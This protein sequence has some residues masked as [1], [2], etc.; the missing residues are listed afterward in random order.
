MGKRGGAQT[1]YFRGKTCYTFLMETIAAFD[2]GDKR[3]GVAFS[4]PFGQ[5]AMPSDTYFRTGRFSEDV[6]AVAQIAL[7]RG[8]SKIVCG[9]PLNA[10]GTT[11]EQTEKTRRFISALQELVGIPV[12]VEDER[13]TTLQARRDLVT[14]GVS[15]KRDK[16]K[17]SV[18]SIAAAYI[19]ESYLSKIKKGGNRMKEVRGEE[20]TGNVIELI[21]D[22][23]TTLRFELLLTFQYKNE[24]YVALTPEKTEDGQDEED[25]VE[26]AIYHIVGSE[27][28]EQL[29]PIEDDAFHDEVFAEFCAQYEDFED[30][31]EAAKLDGDG[32]DGEGDDV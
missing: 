30:A 11:S 9:L 28:D 5:Y 4:D 25:G 23:G 17:K 21:D 31:D 3:I 26:V 22:E 12:I 29:E 1:L 20:G 15:T 24:W 6:K 7:S 8:A 16:Q 10:D 27:D 2:I 14:M 18:D 13:Y 32:E 19:L